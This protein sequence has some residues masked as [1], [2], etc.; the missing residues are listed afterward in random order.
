MQARMQ[1][2]KLHMHFSSNKL[3]TL[4]DLAE[5]KVMLFIGIFPWL[6]N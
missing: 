2:Y 3:W 4:N 5:V 1:T 6:Q